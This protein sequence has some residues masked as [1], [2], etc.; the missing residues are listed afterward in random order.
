MATPAANRAE[1]KLLRMIAEDSRDRF[2]FL[3]FSA[4]WCAPCKTLKPNLKS[5][6]DKHRS[7]ISVIIVDVDKH[8][9][10]AFKYNVRGVPTIVVFRENRQLETQAGLTSS[11]QL[12]KLLKKARNLSGHHAVDDGSWSWTPW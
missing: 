1:E 7:E 8:A 3:T 4:T 5:F 2:V 6:A 11:G 12:K 10:L 9:S